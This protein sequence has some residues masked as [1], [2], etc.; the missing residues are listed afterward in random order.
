MSWDFWRIAWPNAA[1][2]AALAAV[3]FFAMALNV[4]SDERASAV[5]EV[6]VSLPI[7]MADGSSLP[8]P[9]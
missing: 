5:Q 2:V 9:Q 8:R 6:G 3:P 1:I 4:T 7:A